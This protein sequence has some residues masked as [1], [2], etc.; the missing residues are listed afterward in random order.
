MKNRT[1]LRFI[2]TF[3]LCVGAI[4]VFFDEAMT[5]IIKP[6]EVSSAWIKIHALREGRFDAA[7][8]SPVVLAMGDSRMALGFD[9][10][11]FMGLGNGRIQAVNLA[12]PGGEGSA[13][14]ML[15]RDYLRRNPPPDYI[16]YLP[17]AG[18]SPPFLE[19]LTINDAIDL[20]CQGH[21]LKTLIDT[22]FPFLRTGS[23][24]M[25]ADYI[26]AADYSASPTRQITMPQLRERILEHHGFH[27]WDFK[28][29]MQKH[30]DAAELND[31][32]TKLSYFAESHLGNDPDLKRVLDMIRS[33]GIHLLLVVE[34][35]R[36]GSILPYQNPPQ[37]FEEIKAS[38][39][40]AQMGPHGWSQL[41]LHGTQF[42]DNIHVNMDGAEAY[43][44]YL[45]ND[46]CAT[47]HD[48][49]CQ[50][51]FP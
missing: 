50:G 6:P 35:A 42:L 51:S 30:S 18:P 9:P 34:P 1:F 17:P 22:L 39:P 26:G 23:L 29:D 12:M 13:A 5:R 44:T 10:D 19:G 25:M 20:A 36:I 8:G 28:L 45:F 31:N 40:N 38:Y 16:I 32:P 37:F 7:P 49:T 48:Q 33:N 21:S 46:W 27:S 24:R 47:F 14:Y 11:K 41:L 4:I 15:L 3:T 43:T 2:L